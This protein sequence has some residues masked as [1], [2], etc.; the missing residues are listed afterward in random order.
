MSVVPSAH[1]TGLSNLESCATL[2]HKVVYANF[3][4]IG[5]FRQHQGQAYIRCGEGGLGLSFF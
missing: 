5:K 2:L 4:G 1:V 3:D